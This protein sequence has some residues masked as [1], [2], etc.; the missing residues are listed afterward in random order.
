[1]SGSG[2]SVIDHKDQGIPA[3]FVK[4]HLDACNQV[5]KS[6]NSA[7]Q[8]KDKVEEAQLSQQQMEVPPQQQMETTE[9]HHQ[10]D[11]DNAHKPSASCC[12]MSCLRHQSRENSRGNS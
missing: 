8:S 2:Q 4:L 6:A 9:A 1:M 11:V 3:S 7:L 10:I 5:I 12:P